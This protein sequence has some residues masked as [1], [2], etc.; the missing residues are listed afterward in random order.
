MPDLD[1]R[2]TLWEIFLVRDN[3]EHIRR[4]GFFFVFDFL[5]CISRCGASYFLSLIRSTFCGTRIFLS[6]VG[7][8]V[9]CDDID[10][11]DIYCGG[12]TDLMSLMRHFW[13][14]VELD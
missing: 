1:E 5:L 11:P 2:A 9:S 4:R 3:I 6:W 13:E 12:K 8:V 14:V 7:F 10:L